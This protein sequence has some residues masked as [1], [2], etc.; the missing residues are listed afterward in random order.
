M[1]SKEDNLVEYHLAERHM[2]KHYS[3][4]DN[5]NKDFRNSNLFRLVALLVTGESVVDI[6]CGSASFAGILKARGKDVVG[7]EPSSDMRTLAARINPGIVIIP[8]NAEEVNV[9]LPKPV[10]S[11]VMLDV[12]EHIEKDAEQVKKVWTALKK[13]GEFIF[14]VPAHPF[15]YGKR[16]E[17]MGH[18]RRYTKKSLQHLLTG[19]G[20]NIQY[21][22]HWNVLGVL[23]YIVSEKILRRPLG[24]EFRGANK[25]GILAGIIQKGLHLWFSQVEN[26][27]D[28][29]FGLS[30]IG[31]AKKI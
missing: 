9:L 12:L 3:I 8:G 18:Y 31:V 28:F 15:L 13:D 5:L 20:F 30:I 27:I 7:I 23:P 26:N 21:M 25:A 14:V 19:N 29:G 4:L 16:D 2:A 22:R 6:G 10:D 17:Q 11:V 24:S 1:I